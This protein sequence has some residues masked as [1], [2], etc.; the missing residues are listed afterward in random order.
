ME[1]RKIGQSFVHLA[2]MEMFQAARR[3]TIPDDMRRAIPL[4][5]PTGMAYSGWV[6]F[7]AELRAMQKPAGL[8]SAGFRDWA[9]RSNLRLTI[10][11][12]RIRCR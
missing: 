8:R 9:M 7:L 6:R 3:M 12:D 2:I 10:Y 5:S 1:L 4:G 11:K